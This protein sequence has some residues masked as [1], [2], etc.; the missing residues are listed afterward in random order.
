VTTGGLVLIM[1][2]CWHSR[3]ADASAAE[4]TSVVQQST[5]D[6]DGP[7]LTLVVVGETAKALFD[8]AR[9]SNWRDADVAFQAMKTSAA[10]LPT[11]WSN[12][13]LASRLQSRV[14][15]VEDAVS[16]RHRVPTMD[17]ANEITRLV[18][19]LSAEYQTPFPYALVLLDYYGRE[20]QL[21]IA[22]GDRARLKRATEDLQQ[23]WNRFERTI[24][25]RGSVEDVRRVTDSVAQLV[26]AQ[27]PEDF[28][29][30]TRAEQAAVD[31]LKRLFNP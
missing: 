11:T 25:Q 3:A 31:H 2:V 9:L 24:L 19:E 13:D 16:A 15:E 30:A 20:L 21:G 29:A 10:D 27:A 23:T 14:A 7:P 28:V 22:A 18:C 1:A 4:S 26:G 5:R 8:A 17:F 6:V 12:P